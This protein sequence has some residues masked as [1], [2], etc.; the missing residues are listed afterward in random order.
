M[1][2]VNV[3]KMVEELGVPEGDIRRILFLPLPECKA[4]TAE[5]A[6]EEFHRSDP[7]SVE[8]AAAQLKWDKLSLQE[9]RSA[10]TLTEIQTV[11]G[12]ARTG[13][14]AEVEG[15]LRWVQVTEDVPEVL[16]SCV[17]VQLRE[18]AV[19]ELAA[20]FVEDSDT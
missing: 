12:Q 20:R 8:E 14:D 9:V 5:E 6:A 11:L 15:F 4:M 2:Q 19:R 17:D 10:Q 3:A 7:G 13:S 1:R 18:R 16:K